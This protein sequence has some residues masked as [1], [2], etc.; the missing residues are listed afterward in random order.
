M[1]C[2]CKI[3]VQGKEFSKYIKLM[4]KEGLYGSGAITFFEDMY[5]DLCHTQLDLEVAESVIAG[6][7][8]HSSEVIAKAR[9]KIKNDKS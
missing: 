8:P 6:T 2:E 1:S 3:C 4:E 7:W 5:S 9:W